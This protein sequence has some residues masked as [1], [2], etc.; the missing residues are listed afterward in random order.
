MMMSFENV[1]YTAVLNKKKNILT[2]K[3]LQGMEIKYRSKLTLEQIY[4]QLPVFED[5]SIKEIEEELKNIGDQDKTIEK[6]GNKIL[7]KYKLIIL[8]KAKYLS[9]ELF[10]SEK[11]VENEDDKEEYEYT[12]EE[13]E[14]IISDLRTEIEK[15]NVEI[16]D[17]E[18]KIKEAESNKSTLEKGIKSKEASLN[19]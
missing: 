5:Y 16:A 2:M 7:F 12:E 3:L 8:K 10:P 1:P 15:Q 6:E 4:K 9:F 14:Q 18:N 17:L 13:K 11:Y 19:K